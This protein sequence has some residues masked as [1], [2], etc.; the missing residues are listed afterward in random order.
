MHW[1]RK[2]R[3][4]QEYMMRRVLGPIITRQLRG[5]LVS[6]CTKS[7]KQNDDQKF[8]LLLELGQREGG[9]CIE[10]I[11][12]HYVLGERAIQAI[13][14]LQRCIRNYVGAFQ[15]PYMNWDHLSD[16][17]GLHPYQRAR[18]RRPSCLCHLRR[19]ATV[20]TR[21]TQ[22]CV[23]ST[24]QQ[25]KRFR[26]VRDA[27]FEI[28]DAPKDGFLTLNAF[29]PM[30][31]PP[32]IRV[33]NFCPE[34]LGV[35]RARDYTSLM[36]TM[37]GRNY[38]RLLIAGDTLT[39]KVRHTLSRCMRNFVMLLGN[40]VP[41]LILRNPVYK[42]NSQQRCV[43]R[44]P[45]MFCSEGT[46]KALSK[47]VREGFGYKRYVTDRSDSVRSGE[48]FYKNDDQAYH[49][50]ISRGMRWGWYKNGSP[51]IEHTYRID[52]LVNAS[53]QREHGSL[54]FTGPFDSL[55]SATKVNHDAFCRMMER[56]YKH[57][58]SS[59]SDQS[60]SQFQPV[61]YRNPSVFDVLTHHLYSY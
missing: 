50:S 13:P 53:E 5:R 61:S 49:R 57:L 6:R 60:S 19:D 32:T 39:R 10:Y 51:R 36:W 17:E 23:L 52:K 7:P 14:I 54:G 35:V 42:K 2:K 18:H 31:P 9:G 26:L 30:K 29:A 33:L 20:L 43:Q 48:T 11:M 44:K 58:W 1:K 16:Y 40:K 41:R 59:I 4:L 55:T 8:N 27:L 45:L 56:E 46:C 21:E 15:F 38:L 24:L 37:K 3:V 34:R 22:P 47:L 28:C 12:F 25:R